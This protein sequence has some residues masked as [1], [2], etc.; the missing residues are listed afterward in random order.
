[1]FVRVLARDGK[2]AHRTSIGARGPPR[3]LHPCGRGG[4]GRMSA[5]PKPPLRDVAPVRLDDMAAQRLWRGVM[6]RRAGRHGS[7]SRRLALAWLAVGALA[8]AL[9]MSGFYWTKLRLL[10]PE[11]PAVNLLAFADGKPLVAVDAPKDGPR[12]VMLSDG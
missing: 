7:D 6:A 2:A 11:T 5:L 3:R 8:G 10:R 12:S 4:T 1:R 9:A